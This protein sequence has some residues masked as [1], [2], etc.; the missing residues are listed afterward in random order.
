[1]T[2]T[3]LAQTASAD[4]S[5]DW[6]DRMLMA[7]ADEHAGDYIDDQGFTARVMQSLPLAGALPAWRRPAVV[8][9]WVIAGA[10]LAI[11]LPGVALDIA[12]AAYRLVVAQ[13]F[14]LSTIAFI[15]VAFGAATWTAAAV[16]LRRV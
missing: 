14:S 8:M 12:R 10:L 16:A 3:N 7:D 1:M 11:A 9:L 4:S 5:P 15:V 6:I 13:P 2:T